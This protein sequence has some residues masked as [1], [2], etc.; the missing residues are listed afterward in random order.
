[1]NPFVTLICFVLTLVPLAGHAQTDSMSADNYLTVGLVGYTEPSIYLGGENDQDIE[2]VVEA[3]WEGIFYRNDTLGVYLAESDSWYVSAGVGDDVFG[4]HARGDSKTLKDMKSLDKVYTANLT[5]GWITS[6]GYFE[7]GYHHDISD[8]HNSGAVVGRYGAPMEQGP[9]VLDPQVSLTCVGRAV[10]R[11][12]VGVSAQDAKAGRPT[13]QPDQTCMLQ[14]DLNLYYRF[15]RAHHLLLGVSYR[16]Y[17]DEVS[18]SPIVDRDD[19]WSF[20]TGYLYTF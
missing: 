17:G 7:L 1:M 20:N 3:Q 4:D 2:L 15:G 10:S 8:N 19:L 14:S 6:V 18:D 12:Y 5:T 9:W 11:Y 13:Y 16:H